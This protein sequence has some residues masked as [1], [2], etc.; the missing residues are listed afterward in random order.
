[1]VRSVVRLVLFYFTRRH[2]LQYDVKEK[3]Q[4]HNLKND[5]WVYTDV[6]VRVGTRKK[7]RERETEIGRTASI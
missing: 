6:Y 1:M 2:C 7:E 3:E 5:V 4:V